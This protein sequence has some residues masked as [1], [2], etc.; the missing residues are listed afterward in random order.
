MSSSTEKLGYL[1]SRG[2]S[3]DD[4][5]HLSIRQG[6][7]RRVRHFPDRLPIGGPSIRPR[8]RRLPARRPDA[9]RVPPLPPAPRAAAR[10]AARLD[11]P[12]RGSGAPGGRGAGPAEGRVG[13]TRVAAEGADPHGAALVFRPHRQPTNGGEPGCSIGL[14]SNGVAGPSPPTAMQCSTDA[15]DRMASGCWRPLHRRSWGKRWSQEPGRSSR[16]CCRMPTA[17][18]RRWRGRVK[19][20]AARDAVNCPRHH[21][22]VRPRNGSN[23]PA[24][25]RRT[26]LPRRRTADRSTSSGRRRSA[27]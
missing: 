22:A 26:P 9:R 21:S 12:N 4:A 17:T 3:A 19:A 16:W 25:S 14:A 18:W 24:H 1:A 23:P 6:D 8:R 20:S 5:P 2:I 27:S 15:G 11:D 10:E 13:A 7:Q